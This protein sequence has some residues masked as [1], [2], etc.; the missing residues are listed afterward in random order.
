MAVTEV[1]V[2][3]L[4]G[5]PEVS[6]GANLPVLIAQSVRTAGLE[7]KDRNIFV[8]AQKIVSKAEG[9]VLKLED[10]EPSAKAQRAG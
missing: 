7:V 1:S 5:F 8:V 6:R 2:S 3:G 4:P 10:I 9:Q